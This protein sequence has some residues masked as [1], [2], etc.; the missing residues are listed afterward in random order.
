M[1]ASLLALGPLS[2]FLLAMWDSFMIVWLVVPEPATLIQIHVASVQVFKTKQVVC[3]TRTAHHKAR[4]CEDYRHGDDF[5]KLHGGKH[6]RCFNQQL[7]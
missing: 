7:F 1:L 5:T 3:C 2:G 4:R 6:R